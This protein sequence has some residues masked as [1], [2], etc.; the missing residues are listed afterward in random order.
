MDER[1]RSISGAIGLAFGTFFRD[2]FAGDLVAIGICLGLV[3]FV[4]VIAALGTWFLLQ[5]KQSA[6]QFK[7]KVAAKRKKED[8]QYKASKDA[9]EI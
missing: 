7:K 1:P 8:E 5:R 9:P 6:E 2:L 4:A 3:V